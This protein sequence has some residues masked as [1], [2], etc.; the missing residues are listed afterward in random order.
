MKIAICTDIYL[1]QLSGV[2]DSIYILSGNLKKNGHEVRIYAPNLKNAE[3]DPDI[4][5]VPSFSVPGSQNSLLFA[6]PFGMEKDLELFTPDIL[7]IHT[8][9][10]IGIKAVKIAKKLN[11]PILGTD[12]TFPADFLPYI[13]MD[14][15]FLRTYVKKIASKHY[16]N[17]ELVTAPSQSMLDELIEFG[18]TKPTRVISNAI[19]SNFFRPPDNKN[20]T[21]KTIIVFGR[22]AP[23]KNLNTAMDAYLEIIKSHPDAKLVF[24]GEGPYRKELEKKIKQLGLENKIKLLGALQGDRLVKAVNSGDILLITSTSDTQS[25]TTLQAMACEL[26]VVAARAGGLPEYV[27]NDVT[28]FLVEPKNIAGFAQ[29][30]VLLLENPNLRKKLGEEGRKKVLQYSPE[31]ITKKFEE[32]YNEAINIFI[33]RH[34]NKPYNTGS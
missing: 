23:E 32:A 26:P 10:T 25:M 5:R 17:A 12:H 1:P 9:S 13:K 2:A 34:E 14:F 21:G 19:D 24:I 31:N 7:H 20:E 33:K 8:F 3:K 16:N 18:L 6:F 30:I 29:K 28:G 27:E 15:N 11:K 22:L 4:F